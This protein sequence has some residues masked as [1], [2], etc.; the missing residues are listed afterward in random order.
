[1]LFTYPALDE[2]ERRVEAATAKIRT[3]L[4]HQ[5][6][7]EPRR[8][9]GLLARI[10][11]ARALLA[12]NAVE[13]IHVSDEDA[14]AAIDGEDP[15][16][17]D[18]ET[19]RAVVGY[20][21]AMDYILQRRQSPSFMITEDVL[22]AVHFMICKSNLAAR[23]GQ[24]RVGWACVRNTET[25]EVVHEGVDRD[26]LEP[27][28][29]AV[30]AYGNDEE[31]T[32]VLLRAAMTHLSLV[33]LHPFKDGNGRTAR[34]IQTAVLA[35]DGIVA[36]PFSS[37]EEYIGHNQQA[38]YDVLADVGGGG[39]NPK[40]NA[41]PWVRFCLTG[42]YRQA[43]TLLRRTREFERIYMELAS[44]VE[45][46]GLPE[47][48]AMAL[49]QAAF[50]GRVRNSSY[51]VSAEISNNLASRDL[52]ELVR[53]GMLVPEGERRGRFY[54]PSS[55]V[56]HLRNRLRLPKVVDDPFRP[57]TFSGAV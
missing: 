45:S 48:M 23:P 36:P 3:Q 52:G 32:S 35:N 20:R 11:R 40:R 13:G 12:S 51:R 15:A 43:Q 21:E 53:A 44:I 33:M 6:T 54:R 39:W 27:L 1:M 31:V 41:K 14:I 55:T 37:I 56:A 25:G 8:W 17:T 4:R 22:L 28:V 29:Q 9:T 47:R 50:G 5:V 46:R 34:C 42:H 24:Y 7:V 26:Q 19:W 16:S 2:E 57:E 49:L 38:Y 30:L 10:T 18:R